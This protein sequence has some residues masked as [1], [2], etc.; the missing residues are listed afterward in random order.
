M[1]DQQNGNSRNGMRSADISYRQ[2]GPLNTISINSMDSSISKNDHEIDESRNSSSPTDR[3]D[4]DEEN[5]SEGYNLIPEQDRFLPI[6]NIGRIMKR[7]VPT[8]GKIAKEAKECVQECISEFISFLT[9]E[10]SDK[11]LHEK[12]KTITVE[13]MINAMRT[14]DL[15]EYA[16]VLSIYMKR[17]REAHR[18]RSD[19]N[20]GSGVLGDLSSEEVQQ[21]VHRETNSN[22]INHANGISVANSS[23][24]TGSYQSTNLFG[25]N[26][27]EPVVRILPANAQV[28]L[29]VSGNHYLTWHSP[30]GTQIVQVQA[31]STIDT[32]TVQ[33]GR[34][35]VAFVS[36]ES[37]PTT[38]V[39]HATPTTNSLTTSNEQDRTFGQAQQ[40]RPFAEQRSSE[41]EQSRL[42][43]PHNPVNIKF[44]RPA[45]TAVNN[46]IPVKRSRDGK[47]YFLRTGYLPIGSTFSW[48][49]FSCVGSVIQMVVNVCQ[50]HSR[51]VLVNCSVP[52]HG[53]LHLNTLPCLAWIDSHTMLKLVTRLGLHRALISSYTRIVSQPLVQ[54]SRLTAACTS[55]PRPSL[56]PA[57][58]ERLY[59]GKPPLTLKTVEERVLL[60]L[61]LY[62]KIDQKKLTLDSH[63]TNDLGLDSLDHVEV[64]MAIEDEF[65]F[66]IPDGDADNLK[67]PRDIFKY[68]CD[69]EDIFE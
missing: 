5:I 20:S 26:G 42:Q 2:G 23:Y 67:T 53:A 13:D 66:E 63:F 17:F 12:R 58:G 19:Q 49:I 31:A 6:A 1:V 30:E 27:A 11:C 50:V 29:D 68:V 14:L 21:S 24:I 62:D 56:I 15:G 3:I 40:F 59:S 39:S 22:T 46:L 9:S 32:S 18:G 41:M 4:G 33:L 37:V 36:T 44:T 8:H 43:V 38:V 16:D 7:A 10:A 45:T 51:S 64:I 55:L 54:A 65:G 61:S 60:V 47:S 52:V 48:R 34:D 69:R 57:N 28:L 25:N 35:E